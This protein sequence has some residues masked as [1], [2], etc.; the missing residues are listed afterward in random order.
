MTAGP[1]VLILAILLPPAGYADAQTLPWPGESA[2]AQSASP[3]PQEVLSLRQEQCV[4]EVRKRA[5]EAQQ[6]EFTCPADAL[7]N[8]FN[9]YRRRVEFSEEQE[10]QGLAKAVS[11]Q[12]RS[13]S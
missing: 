1:R 11:G 7:A 5:R 10:R 2:V 8:C 13:L 9:M 12:L 6:R 4:R 3:P